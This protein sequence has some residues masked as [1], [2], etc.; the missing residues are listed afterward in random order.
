MS[1]L[2]KC[3]NVIIIS[4]I[5]HKKDNIEFYLL[6]EKVLVSIDKDEEDHYRICDESF[7]D[8]KNRLVLKRNCIN[9]P[10][11]LSLDAIEKLK[12]ME[13][14]NGYMKDIA[15]DSIEKKGDFEF[16]EIQSKVMFYVIK[17]G[18]DL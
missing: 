17:K 3:K 18:L 13:R 2:N 16:E 11:N 7:S 10:D 4:A 9:C 5:P 14:I 6:N 12:T 15:L 1:I 8:F